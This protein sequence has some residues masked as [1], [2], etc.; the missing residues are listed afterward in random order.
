MNLSE[1]FREEKRI[2]PWLEKIREETRKKI[3]IMEVCGGHT[4]AIRQYGIQTLLPPG[5]ELLSGPGCPVC[6]TDQAFID[7][8]IEAARQPG[9]ILLTY[10]DMLRVPGS[11]SSLEKEK[12]AG[13]DIRVIGSTLEALHICRMNPD[14]NIVF[15]AIGF[16][17]TTPGTAVAILQA[18]RENLKNFYIICAHKTMPQA[19]AALLRGGS[20]IDGYIGPG[21]VC[22]I[23]GSRL[24]EPLAEEYGIPIVISGFE[25]LDLI[26]SI[27][28]LV[29]MLHSGKSGVHIQY[30]RLVHHEGNRKAREI[31]AAIFEPSDELWRGIGTIPQ[32]GLRLR[33]E[34]EEFDAGAVFNLR[35][36]SGPEPRGCLCGAIMQGKQKPTDCKLFGKA[37][38]PMHPVGA[39]MVSSEGACNA[40]YRYGNS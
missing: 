25:P 19:M 13:K 38:I 15:A 34:Y 36:V 31:V 23:A 18:K 16:E 7:L 17:T 3:R 14:K 11:F 4:M 33:K 30:S 29:K 35:P 2:A 10:G 5:I 26:Q 27:Y 21:H 12:A 8:A 32:S 1:S 40:W 6:V 22:T 9:F 24:F 39:C 37:C 20:T 28:F